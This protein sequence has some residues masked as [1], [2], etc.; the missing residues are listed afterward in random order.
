MP[1]YFT[2]P[3]GKI[4]ARV[5]DDRVVDVLGNIVFYLRENALSD[6]TGNIAAR[7]DENLIVTPQ[8]VIIGYVFGDEGILTTSL[9]R[10]VGREG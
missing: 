3:Q 5:V 1:Q 8:G 10:I 2:T 7:F 9:G 4:I 6:A